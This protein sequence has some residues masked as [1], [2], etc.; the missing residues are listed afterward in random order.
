[1]SRI[2]GQ[3]HPVRRLLPEPAET[4]VAEQLAGLDLEDLAHP[5][6]P[7]LVLNFATTIDGRAAI[8][9]RSGPIGSETDTE[10]LERLRTRVDAVMIGAGTMRAERYGRI[11]SDPD[12]RAYRE[13]TGLAHD[14]LAVI[15]SN[16]MELPWDAGLFTDGGGRVV[17]FTASEEEPP[18]TATPVTVV[19]HPDG[20]ELDRALGWLLAE[21]G[22]RSVLCEGGP[23]LHGRLREGGLADELFLTIAPKIAGGEGPRILEGALPDVEGVELAWLLES[24]GELFARYRGMS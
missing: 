24:E 1:M 4:T 6:R 14:P 9:G 10:M 20:V 17:V 19:R 8:S 12:L 5:D 21:R 15:V 16:R 11:V 22:I 7:H 13:R 2:P 18:E 23:T 3:T